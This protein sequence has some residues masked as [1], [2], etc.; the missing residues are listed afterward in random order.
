MTVG[1]L[2]GPIR[3]VAHD[4]VIDFHFM[5][6]DGH[7]SVPRCALEFLNGRPYLKRMGP[8]FRTRG[9]LNSI[10]IYIYILAK[11][12][13]CKIPAVPPPSFSSVV[14]IGR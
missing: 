12:D 8:V 14:Y 11:L 5:F 10:H 3:N 13:P 9:L 1:G 4:C 6:S 7:T 2:S